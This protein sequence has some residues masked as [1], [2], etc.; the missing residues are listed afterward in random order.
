MYQS[1][2]S[3]NVFQA[4]PEKTVQDK[5]LPDKIVLNY[6]IVLKTIPDKTL[7]K[8]RQKS[9]RKKSPQI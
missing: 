5:T 8:Y 1:H 9:S 7:T 4:C 2:A 3:I 6:K